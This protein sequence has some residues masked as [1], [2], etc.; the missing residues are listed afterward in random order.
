MIKKTTIILLLLLAA[1]YAGRP[2]GAAPTIVT[3]LAF[4]AVTDDTL[5]LQCPAEE[6]MV[7]ETYYPSPYGYYEELRGDKIIVGDS[8]NSYIDEI[9]LPPSGTITFEPLS[10]DPGSSDGNLKEG[11]LYYQKAIGGTKGKFRV[12]D[13][14]AWQD[15]GGGGDGVPDET[16]VCTLAD[17]CSEGWLGWKEYN[18]A[19]GNLSIAEEKF[20]SVNS[21]K[22]C[23]K[24]ASLS[25]GIIV[26]GSN[27][28]CPAGY[29]PLY[30]KWI[31]GACG[32]LGT[33]V[34]GWIEPCT[35]SS[36][37]MLWGNPTLPPQCPYNKFLCGSVCGGS[38]C[39]ADCCF[40]DVTCISP[41]WSDVYCSKS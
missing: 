13:G 15:V 32:S 2:Q 30:R 9:N 4:A 41:G 3:G 11:A 33:S 40:V 1:Q 6:S 34:C 10:D 28:T 36:G 35:T 12:Y 18:L 7:F 25:A 21:M 38:Y 23:V 31:A 16:V 22:A 5:C 17:A 24:S 39:T 20:C 8:D 27:P 37:W 29:S 14:S 26:S 19:T